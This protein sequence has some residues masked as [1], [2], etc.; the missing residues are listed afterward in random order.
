MKA[1]IIDDERL[2]RAELRR[3]LEKHPDVE[4]VGEARDAEDALSQIGTMEPDLL[5]LDIQMPGAN[6]FELLEQLDRVPV[7]IF[8]TA[9]DDYALKAFEVNALDYLLKPVAPERLAAALAK[10]GGVKPKTAVAAD[11]QIFVKDGER[12]WFVALRDIVLLES[13]GNYTRLYFGGHRPLVLRSLNYLED[14]LDAAMFFRASR[15]HILNLKFIEAMDAWANGGFLVR[16]KGSIE[17]EMS[18][19]QA[20]KFKDSMSL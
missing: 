9:Y 18:R 7:V 15:K 10:V 17:V 19:R 16:L 11:Q 8:T 6:G 1:L 2:A 3:L 4:I 5:F 13:E 14:R 20:Q 12:C